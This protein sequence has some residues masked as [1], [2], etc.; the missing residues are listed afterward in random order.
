MHTVF[1]YD[2]SFLLAKVIIKFRI[3]LI[4]GIKST[5]KQVFGSKLDDIN[6]HDITYETLR[7]SGP[8]GQNVNKVETAVRATHIPSGISVLASDMR[9]Q[10]QNKKLAFERLTMKLSAIE[11][12]RQMQQTHDVWMNHNTLERGN[13]VKKF[14]GDL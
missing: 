13:P 2:S 8:G 9:S 4:L 10:V 11:E 7:S 12:A 1:S 5:N 6:E 14:N 3:I